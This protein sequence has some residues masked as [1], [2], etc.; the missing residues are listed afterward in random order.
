MSE[1]GFISC[2]GDHETYRTGSSGWPCPGFEI[3]I[4]DDQGRAL[5][6]PTVGEIC[7]RG[8]S[9]TPGYWNDPEA[10]SQAFR[11]QWFFTGD[12][13]YLDSDGYLYITD[14]KKD[15]IIKGGENISPSEIEQVLYLHPAIAETAVV[16]IPDDDFGEQICAVIQLRP[17]ATATEDETREHAARY[18]GKFKVPSQV[19]F[20]AAL[21]R[22]STGKVNKQLLREQLAG[23][24][25]TQ[26]SDAR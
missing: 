1:A 5:P 8:A 16:G 24:R 26:A 9:I 20:Q 19:V 15:L 4:V 11:E 18:I 25:E 23:I 22:T 7:I 12:V 6:P 14:R 10:S 21:P 3:R 17:G 13:G 2:Y